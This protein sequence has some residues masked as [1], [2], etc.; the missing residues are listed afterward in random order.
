MKKFRFALQPLATVRG[1]RELRAREAFALTV[2]AHTRATQELERQRGALAALEAV[3]R[4]DR[5]GG[6]RAADQIAFQRG[7]LGALAAEK[8]AVDA[9][10]KARVAMEAGRQAWLEA[11]RGVRVVESLEQKARRLHRFELEREVQAQLDDR[12]SAQVAR[13]TVE[14]S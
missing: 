5:S 11:R 13:R 6:F 12:T 2:G 10:E 9:V 4:S 7:Y 8:K 3:L 1:I 14:T